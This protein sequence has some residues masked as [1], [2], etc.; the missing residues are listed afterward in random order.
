MRDET[1]DDAAKAR[2]PKHARNNDDFRTQ[3]T[4]RQRRDLPKGP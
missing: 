3:E 2:P 4:S 1:A